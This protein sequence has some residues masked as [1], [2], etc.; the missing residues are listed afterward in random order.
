[1]VRP[2][3]MPG[4]A[5]GVEI[6]S[7]GLTVSTRSRRSQRRTRAVVTCGDGLNHGRKFHAAPGGG[8][9]GGSIGPP[10]RLGTSHGARPGRPLV[11]A[12]DT[13]LVVDFGAQY[14]QLIARRVREAK[15]YSEIVPHTMP[16][17]EMLAKQPERDHPL[18]WTVLGLRARCA[19]SST[20]RWSTAGCRC[21]AS[22]TASWPW[23]SARRHVAHTGQREYGRTRVEV[24]A[25]GHPARRTARPAHLLDV[26]RRRGGRRTRGLHG[27][28]P[29]RRAP[30]WPRSRTSSAGWPGC[31][32]TPR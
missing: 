12:H 3:D 31:S 5:D 20:R 30:R 22:A 13:V 24:L 26:P 6:P 25:P 7:R 10:D 21:S 9:A 32:G 23:P 16:V 11:T 4:T 17:E 8:P 2:L 14:A 1:M 18:R 27:Q 19:R 15:V 28:R 29:A